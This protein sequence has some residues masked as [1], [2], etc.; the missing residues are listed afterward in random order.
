MAKRVQIFDALMEGFRVAI[1][2]KKGRQVAL[3]VTEIPRVKPKRKS[4][5]AT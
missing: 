2:R 5:R 3:R 1:A 4:S